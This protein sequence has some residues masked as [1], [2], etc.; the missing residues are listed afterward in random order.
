MLKLYYVRGISE[1]DTPHFNSL[2]EQEEYFEE[3]LITTIDAFFP[4]HYT[5]R[6]QFSNDDLDFNS[7]INY[8]SLDFNGKTYYYFITDMDYIAEDLI[9][10][11]ITMD[12][13]QTFMFNMIFHNARLE[14][15]TIKRWLPNGAI[16]RDYIREN[17]SSNIFKLEEYK[18]L[19][20]DNASP[21]VN[22]YPNLGFLVL[23]KFPNPTASDEVVSRLNIQ[24]QY[25][26]TEYEKPNPYSTLMDGTTIM[27]APV[28][29][30]CTDYNPQTDGRIQII[31]R[32]TN[33]IDSVVYDK[34]L[35]VYMKEFYDTYID[36]PNVYE[37]YYMRNLNLSGIRCVIDYENGVFTIK[38]LCDVGGRDGILNINTSGGIISLY[39]ILI[40]D[41]YR[42][43]NFDFRKAN[44]FIPFNYYL[45]P[46]LIDENYINFTFGERL[47]NTTYPLSKLPSTTLQLHS[48]ND[49][50]TGYRIYWILDNYNSDDVYFTTITAQTKEYAML[51]ND[52]WKN[53]LANNVGTMFI[54][55]QLNF[56]EDI[57]SF[58]S[59]KLPT[60]TAKQIT[61]MANNFF[62]PDSV[63]QGGVFTADYI[64]NALDV[65]YKYEYVTNIDSVATIYESIGYKVDKYI[66][67]DNP[68]KQNRKIFNYIKCSEIDLEINMLCSQDITKD[69][70]NRY[71]QGL[72]FWNIDTMNNLSLNL[73][74]VCVYD[75]LEEEEE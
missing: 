25:D 49:L 65:M 13:I 43:F 6:L 72:R 46:Q 1:T 57:I 48:Y 58:K 41:N 37:M 10:I 74:D 7:Q 62:A 28:F 19:Q 2:V 68:L 67:N 55:S 5:D 59:G 14:R 60:N 56:L 61:T 21:E 50:F 34:S 8:M 73:G 54:G 38:I 63:K 52:A 53:Y 23:K 26:P 71:I 9:S 30:L 11:S 32:R 18:N 40:E 24:K 31:R 64:S 42:V 17:Y 35:A 16:N 75:N 44:D 66:G 36:D 69:I 70:N 3:K 4:P 39:D 20:Y 29:G 33:E 12:T 45:V 22:I 47:V 27:I 15:E 51:K